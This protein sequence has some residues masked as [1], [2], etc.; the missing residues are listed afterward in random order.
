MD[1]YTPGSPEWMLDKLA[2]EGDN[3]ASDYDD[4]VGGW[5]G[6]TVDD[7]GSVKT[8]VVSWTPDGENDP[9]PT[10]Q[11]RWRLVPESAEA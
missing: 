6:W 7:A 11:T 9:G 10:I 8:L 1:E 5:F 4:G 2:N 3:S